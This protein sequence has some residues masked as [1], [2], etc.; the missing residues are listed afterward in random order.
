MRGYFRGD[1]DSDEEWCARRLLARIN[2]HTVKRLRKQVEPVSPAVYMRFLF[3]WHEI[4][5]DDTEGPDA[6][7]RAVDRLQGF[8]APAGAWESSL[9]PSRVNGYFGSYLDELLTSGQYVWLRPVTDPA[10]GR[11]SGPVRNTRIIIINRT[12]LG[13][14]LP[15]FQRGSPPELSSQATTVRDALREHR[16]TFFADLVRI[17]GLL[18]T[19]VEAALGELVVNGLVTSDSFAGLRALITPSAKRASFSRPRR[20]GRA[21]VDAAGRW[22]LIEHSLPEIASVSGVAA[23]PP[24]DVRPWP[25]QEAAVA[26]LADASR[27]ADR[28][29][30]GDEDTPAVWTDEGI[31]QV[32]RTLLD[33][34]GV[35]FRGV[36]QRESRRMPTWRQLWRVFRRLEARGEV[37]GGRFV[38]SFAGEQFAWPDAV[39]QLRRVQRAGA[40]DEGRNVVISAA[41]P[42]NLAGIITPGSRVPAIATNRLLYRNG[43]PVAVFVAGEFEWLG[44]GDGEGDAA[45]EWV[46][47]TLLIRNDPKIVYL[48]GS[49][50]PS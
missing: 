32:V 33:C 18:R 40:G 16:A 20:R 28:G 50:R 23:P 44:D 6:V 27:G 36:M 22:S 12:E 21:S 14:W 41:D 1:A 10:P 11:K 4:G 30:L 9:L 37:R 17:T 8:A 25:G 35:V 7:R 38:S 43:L 2:R 15:L 31:E 29:V 46:A 13:D 3:D 45:A 48:P 42:L 19:H 5:M 26:A 39:D 49:R 34:Y 24:S 47:R